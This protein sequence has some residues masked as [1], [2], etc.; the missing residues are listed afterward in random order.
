MNSRI[1]LIIGEIEEY[2]DG[3][4]FQ[5][6]SNTKILVDK[7]HFEELIR[8]LRKNIPDEVKRYQKVI[9]QKEEIL[10][11]A[12]EKADAMISD[13]QAQTDHMIEEHE[14]MQQ[15]YAQANEI[16]QQ[17]MDQAQHILDEASVDANNMRQSVVE[18]TDDM[19]MELNNIVTHS[20]DTAQAK[21]TDLIDQ[22]KN[23][24][25][26]IDKNRSELNPK[27]EADKNLPPE[28]DVL[29]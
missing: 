12:R 18:Y 3:C 7:E 15:A 9:S 29:I 19:L 11:D 24:Q 5:P 28:P 13:A 14:I 17:A 10:N 22:L 21:Y 4:K 1:E 20:I 25:S 8:D 27:E 26:V 2:V 23:C 16:V 6:L